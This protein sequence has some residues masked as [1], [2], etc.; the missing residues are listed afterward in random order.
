M[1]QSVPDA[2]T[3]VV[4]DDE[5]VF[6]HLMRDILSSEG[7]RV[8]IGSVAG[9]ALSLIRAHQPALVILDLV[10]QTQEAGLDVLRE[11]RAGADTAHLPVLLL[12][13]NH[14]FV[15]DRARAIRDA[16]T[17]VMA[18]PFELNELLTH[19]AACVAAPETSAVSREDER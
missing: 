11:I 4:I 13:A 3:I 1:T 16:D 18:K 9:D 19:V 12:T 10:M 2:P 14:Q 15:R 6:L 8:L 5:D 7:Y 17:E